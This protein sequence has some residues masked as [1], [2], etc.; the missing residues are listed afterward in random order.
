MVFLTFSLP[1]CSTDAE[2]FLVVPNRDPSSETLGGPGGGM[3]KC[4]WVSGCVK[5]KWPGAANN[6]KAPFLVV[7][8]FG[9]KAFRSTA[10]GA[11]RVLK[12]LEGALFALSDR[13]ALT[14]DCTL[15]LVF[16]RAV[17]G[18]TTGGERCGDESFPTPPFRWNLVF[19]AA[20]EL[21]RAGMRLGVFARRTSAL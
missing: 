1:Y 11:V 8:V 2:S 14:A 3:N 15:L 19:V 10:A 17:L 7:S 4:W 5:S 13:V 6:N 20:D 18:R 9:I 12:R 16:P 21:A